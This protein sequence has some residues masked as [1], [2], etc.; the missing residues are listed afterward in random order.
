M[1][2]ILMCPT[3]YELPCKVRKSRTIFERYREDCLGL[4]EWCGWATETEAWREY[5]TIAS[6]LK[7][8]LSIRYE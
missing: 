4:G 7:T 8:K 1:N 2:A 5:L 3:K 6:A